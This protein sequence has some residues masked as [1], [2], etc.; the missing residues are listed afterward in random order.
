MSRS[1]ESIGSLL[2]GFFSYFSSTGNGPQFHWMKDVLALR[3]PSGILSKEEKGWVKA[4]TEESEGRRV[5][6]RYLFCIEDPFELSHN[7]SRTVTHH[8]I[9]A[10]R[11]EFRRAK[12]ILTSIGNGMPSREGA[13]MEALVEV[14]DLSTAMESHNINEPQGTHI[15]NT[16][17]PDSAIDHTPRGVL[18]QGITNRSVQ[19]ARDGGL[20]RTMPQPATER[21]GPD[22]MDDASFPSLGNSKLVMPTKSQ[23]VLRT[24]RERKKQTAS[25]GKSGVREDHNSSEISGDRAKEL[26]ADIR[27]KND[28]AAS[29]SRPQGRSK[30]GAGRQ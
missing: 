16:G 2:V 23:M 26:L 10:I 8:G 27:K 7:V 17:N 29:A 9:V 22:V 19:Q 15:P 24:P 13:L 14:E 21:K 4:V 20:S 11:D 18:Q 6:Q 1:N 3:T 12:R 25:K 5:Q 28:E 30:S